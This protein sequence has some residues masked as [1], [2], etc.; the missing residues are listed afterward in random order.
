MKSTPYFCLIILLLSC[1]YRCSKPSET[2]SDHPATIH[3][4]SNSIILTSREKVFWAQEPDESHSHLDYRNPIDIPF[5]NSSDVVDT[6]AFRI[7][8]DQALRFYFSIALLL[9]SEGLS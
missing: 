2:V 5:N 7:F 4:D 6:A 9:K 3:T 1:F 8:L